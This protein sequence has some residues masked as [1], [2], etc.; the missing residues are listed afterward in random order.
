MTIDKFSFAKK[1][2]SSEAARI[3][4]TPLMQ[5][6]RKRNWAMFQIKSIQAQVCNLSTTFSSYPRT[7]HAIKITVKD[8]EVSINKEYEKFKRDNP[9]KKK[10][11]KI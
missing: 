8:L 9:P 3:S 4:N 7:I 11:K 5:M 10:G 1:H 6:T 2:L